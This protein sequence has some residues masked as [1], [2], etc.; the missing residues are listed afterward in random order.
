MPAKG[1]SNRIVYWS[2]LPDWTNPTLTPN[3]DVIWLMPAKH[4]WSA[5]VYNRASHALLR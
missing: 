2:R 4:Y 3:P 1:K 5:T